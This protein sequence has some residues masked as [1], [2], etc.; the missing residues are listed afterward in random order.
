PGQVE[1][2]IVNLALNARDAMPDGGRVTIETANVELSATDV[3]RH[4]G[5]QPGSYVMLAVSDTGTGMAPDTI[6]HIFEPFFTTKEAGRGT[7]LGLSTVYGIVKQSGGDVSVYSEPGRGTSFKIYLPSATRRAENGRP[8]R[9]TEPRPAEG[10]ET[11]LVV[12]DD[13]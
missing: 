2:V 10:S 13:K 7:G 6:A 5:V 4:L 12:E 1:Q 8:S 11:L 3:G 9:I